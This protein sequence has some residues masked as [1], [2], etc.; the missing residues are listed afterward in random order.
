MIAAKYNKVTRFTYQ[1]PENAP[2]KNLK[3]FGVDNTVILRG[4]YINTKGNFGEEPVA[5]TDNAYVN[6]PKHLANDVSNMM[7][8]EEFITAVN[9]GKVG[10]KVR[11]YEDTK[12][13]KGT[14]YSVEWVD[15]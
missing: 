1:M 12:F 3:D 9:E 14:C 2:Y 10:F 7:A 5:M 6:L 11:S 8:D 4:L 15:L 13:G